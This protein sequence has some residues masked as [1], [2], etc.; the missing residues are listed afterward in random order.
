MQIAEVND[1]HTKLSKKVP[2]QLEMFLCHWIAQVPKD[3]QQ[4]CADINF[5]P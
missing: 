2:E 4:R 3:G 5:L 1:F